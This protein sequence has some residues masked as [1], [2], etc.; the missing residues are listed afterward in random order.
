MIDKERTGKVITFLVGLL[1]ALGL[2]LVVFYI[3][4]KM[5]TRTEPIVL[6]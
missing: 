2:V 4:Q 1:L 6:T 3:R 5:F